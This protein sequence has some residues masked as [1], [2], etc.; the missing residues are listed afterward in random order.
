M[1]KLGY[2]AVV[3]VLLAT[4]IAGIARMMRNEVTS[5]THTNNGMRSSDMR[6]RAVSAR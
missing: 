4:M 5:I 6:V 1:R 2:L 3:L